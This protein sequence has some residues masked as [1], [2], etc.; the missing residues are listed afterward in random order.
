MRSDIWKVKLMSIRCE[1]HEIECDVELTFKQYSLVGE[2]HFVG[3][4]NPRWKAKC[5]QRYELQI[6]EF[7]FA[8]RKQSQICRRGGVCV[9]RKWSRCCSY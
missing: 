9:G 5:V 2:L 6:R 8:S 1:F 4:Y 7:R 3:R